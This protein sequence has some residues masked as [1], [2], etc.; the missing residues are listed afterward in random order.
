MDGHTPNQYAMQDPTTQYP[1]PKFHK[2]PQSA[3]GLAQD[4]PV[5]P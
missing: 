4:G 2:Q 3:P 5:G 1:Q